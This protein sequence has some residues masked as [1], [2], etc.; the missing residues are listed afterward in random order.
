MRY[1]LNIYLLALSVLGWDKEENQTT[2]TGSELL[3]RNT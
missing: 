2:Q 3:T 1:G